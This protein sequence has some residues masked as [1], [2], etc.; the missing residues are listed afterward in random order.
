[1]AV[2]GQFAIPSYFTGVFCVSC[3]RLLKSR[4]SSLEVLKSLGIMVFGDDCAIN[5][6]SPACKI[7]SRA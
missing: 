6:G 1:M 2:L 4:T 5:G 3:T 7:P